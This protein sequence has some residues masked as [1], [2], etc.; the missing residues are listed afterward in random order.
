MRL[1][2]IGTLTALLLPLC[3]ASL[4]AEGVTSEAKVVEN[5]L[6]TLR[7]RKD[8]SEE[9]SVEA[10]KTINELKDDP[11][12]RGILIAESLRLVNPDFRNALTLLG[13]ENFASASQALQPL[14]QA[15]DP[16]LA[17]ESN[18]FLARA[19]IL[20]ERFEEALPRL[21]E[22]R[23]KFADK[24]VRGGES[25]FLTGI[26]EGQLLKREEAV[27][28]LT[29]FI[30]DYPDAPERMRV[31][32]FRQLEFLKLIEEGTLSDVQLRMEFSRRRLSLED[33][34]DNTRQQQ[35]KIT[36]ILAKLIKE[37]EKKEAQSKGKGEGEGKGQKKSEGQAGESEG[38]GKGEGKQGGQTGGGSK[39]ID[40]DTAERLHRG[41]P[42]SPWS[43]L[44]D[45]ERDP[46]FNALK[47]KFPGRYQELIEQYYKSFE[48]ED[49]G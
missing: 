36:D 2:M 30:R 4:A 13:E 29:Q 41:G 21:E 17:A 33:P 25:L 5:F 23:G 34:G 12:G 42:Q 40:S 47:E 28:A 16:Y 22:L 9:L 26:A 15:E 45:R 37:A 6:Q 11:Y 8:I 1:F 32:A 46:V 44:R 27:E 38:E 19:Y 49:E 18:Y 35:V 3:G 31:G 39:G 10:E 48:N 43:K 20:E 14:T 7:D 24:T